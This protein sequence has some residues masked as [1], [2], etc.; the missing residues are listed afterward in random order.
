MSHRPPRVRRSRPRR[1][2][3]TV[4]AT[5]LAAVFASGLVAPAAAA[6]D[7]AL[8]PRIVLDLSGPGWSLWL[9]RAAVWEQDELFAPPVDLAVLPVNPPTGGWSALAAPRAPGTGAA[10]TG[11]PGTG[12]AGTGAAGVIAVSVPGTVE[13]HTWNALAAERGGDP[14]GADSAGD[15]V[16][17]SWW[18]RAF[19]V[20]AEMLAPVA[21]APRHVELRFDAVRQ[22]A[23]VFLNERVVGYDVVGNTPFR[24]DCGSALRAG[25]NVL[26]VRITDPGGNFSWQDADALHWG[27]HTLPASHGFG[28]VTGPVRLQSTAAVRLAD[29]AVLNRPDPHAIEVVAR[30]ENPTSATLTA[31]LDVTILDAVT[32]A[33]LEARARAPGQACPPGRSEVRLLLTVP[34]APLWSPDD[35]RLFLCRA[36]LRTAADALVT[37]VSD[38]RD[39][40][41][42]GDFG[43]PQDVAEQRFGFRWFDVDGIADA[44]APADAAAPAAGP[45]ASATRP[46]GARTALG[47]E[48]SEAMTAPTAAG[49][50]AVVGIALPV[51]AGA[52][53]FRLNGRRIVLRS[54]ISWGF[55]PGSGMVPTPELAREQVAVAKSLG[56]NMLSHHRG[57]AAP[58]LLDLHDELGLLAYEEP[59]GYASHGGDDVCRALAREKLLRLVERDRSHP[60]LAIVNLINEETAPPTEAQRR[61]LADAH[62]LDPTRVLTFTSGWAPDGAD[63]L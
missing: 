10:D 44:P 7:G 60:S 39:T 9:D 51:D 56:L 48:A 63:P 21:S 19:D 41:T 5:V 34:G 33:P 55:W 37:G 52:A 14:P 53:V 38:A 59:G 61:D 18:W 45:A 11:A 1:G 46:V 54:A 16:G 24:A 4:L 17:V 15:Y 30:V 2:L 49:S 43:P 20:P 25:R 3:R 47:G 50:A 26:A 6:P 62:A 40:R 27:S 57:L 22:R 8:S 31:A 36:E 28:G 29:L 12:A 23:E 42:A 32:R 35:P 13:Q 58:G